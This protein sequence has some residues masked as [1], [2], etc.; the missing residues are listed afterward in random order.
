[1]SATN[2][3]NTTLHIAEHVMKYATER[4][5]RGGWGAI[6]ECFSLQE[7]AEVFAIRGVRTNSAGLNYA[8]EMVKSRREAAL[9]AE[10]HLHTEE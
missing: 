10:A 1:M 9:N 3:T 2:T 7:L 6:S 5:L 4:Q 8:R